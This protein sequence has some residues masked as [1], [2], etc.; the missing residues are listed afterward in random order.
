MREVA[1]DLARIEF[2]DEV[3]LHLNREGDFRQV[4]NARELRRLLAV[5]DFDEVRHVALGE[6]V[7]FEHYCELLGSVLDL[8]DVADLHLVA[9]DVDA[10]AVHLDVAVVDEL[11][12]GEHRRYELGAID[13]GVETALE[14]AD[15]VLA[16]VA[17]ETGRLD[18]D[19]VE[20]TLGNVGVVALELLLGAELR[21][22]VGELALAA[23][24]VLAGAVFTLV[25]GALRAA[26]DVLAHTAIDFILRLT[27]LSHRVLFRKFEF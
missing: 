27:A 4:R 12:G 17:L 6:L 23:L 15:Q 22:E 10:L 18:V 7:G 16:R 20:L 26:P 8:D 11:A 13:D 25:D 3:R 5:I 21:T 19:G 9:G 14:E 1:P 24:A 2:D